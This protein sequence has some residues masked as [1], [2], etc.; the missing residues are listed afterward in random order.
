MIHH[1]NHINAVVKPDR[2][3]IVRMRHSSSYPDFVERFSYDKANKPNIYI[4]KQSTK[5]CE[6][7]CSSAR[8]AFSI[9]MIHLNAKI[10]VLITFIVQINKLETA[11]SL[12]K[13]LYFSTFLNDVI[14]F[15]L[16]I[17]KKVR[18]AMKFPNDE[19]FFP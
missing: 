3:W 8:I 15:L 2:K 17:K 7:L 4:H 14:F 9:C 19:V 10:D 16:F 18:L 11:I 5:R 1:H 12:L 13:M 6:F